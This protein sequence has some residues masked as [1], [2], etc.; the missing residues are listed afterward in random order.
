MK[1]IFFCLLISSLCLFAAVSAADFSLSLESEKDRL[2]PGESLQITLNTEC[3]EDYL[4]YAWIL[5]FVESD[6]PKEFVDSLPPERAFSKAAKAEWRY[7]NYSTTWFAAEK[8]DLRQRT[9]KLVADKNWPLGDYRA[10]IRVL[11]R[12]R[13]K[14]ATDS[15][16]YV[17]KPFSFTL[18]NDENAH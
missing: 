16:K 1:H 5:S 8:R 18:E 10:S 11:F 7:L 17:G 3:P 4:P 9:I 12:K 2:A 14:P 15:D 13:D 6:V